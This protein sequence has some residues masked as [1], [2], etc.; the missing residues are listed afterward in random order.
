[1]NLLLKFRLWRL[2]RSLRSERAERRVWAVKTLGNLVSTEA[3][4][5]ELVRGAAQ[6]GNTDVQLAVIEV[7]AGVP[8]TEA[9][10]ALFELF[11][12][13]ANAVQEAAA[14]LIRSRAKS[15]AITRLIQSLLAKVKEK[16]AKDWML[17]I[18]LTY[19]W[20]ENQDYSAALEMLDGKWADS[21]EARVFVPD[22]IALLADERCGIRCRAAELLGTI[23]DPRAAAA[24]AQA[25]LREPEQDRE[26]RNSCFDI[27]P[28]EENPNHD[29]GFYFA[30]DIFERALLAQGRAA[31]GPCLNLLNGK[32]DILVR[33]IVGVIL[34]EV[35]WRGRTVRERVL[36]ALWCDNP[37]AAAQEGNEAFET[38]MEEALEVVLTR[39]ASEVPLAALRKLIRFWQDPAHWS[40]AG[41][42]PDYHKYLV[43]TQKI[44]VLAKTE[45]ARRDH[46]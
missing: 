36:V 18:G 24:I 28:P 10:E 33:P 29:K 20:V 35:G 25:L 45:V 8:I 31:V 9:F 23:C 2:A 14:H 6:D 1:M 32:T 44:G 41:R 39:R 42:P 4:A 27:R 12:T 16:Q 17:P 5:F 34:R 21:S 40:L 22:I 19:F 46:E 26:D 13:G 3:R 7:L 43:A 11:S 30:G 15:R 37:F 38:L